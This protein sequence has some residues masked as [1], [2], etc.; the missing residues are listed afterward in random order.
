MTWSLS[1]QGRSS[2]SHL[3]RLGNA[4]LPHIL[5]SHAEMYSSLEVNLSPGDSNISTSKERLG[6]GV[7]NTKLLPTLDSSRQH[8]FVDFK[9]EMGS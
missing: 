2:L 4:A 6:E 3:C 8:H 7:R 9:P 5:A 1:L